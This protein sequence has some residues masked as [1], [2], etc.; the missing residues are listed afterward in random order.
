M[1]VQSFNCVSCLNTILEL[2]NGENVN[3]AIVNECVTKLK[4]A[5]LLAG[6]SHRVKVGQSSH[7]SKKGSWY[8][9][10]CQQ[11]RESFEWAE[12]IYR[13]TG[14][15][16]DR[17]KM[18]EA[19]NV[20]RKCCR[21][22]RTRQHVMDADE[23]VNLGRSN[24]KQ[25]WRKLK[26]R[27]GRVLGDCDFLSYFKKLGDLQS[28]VLEEVEQEIEQWEESNSFHSDETLD[29]EISMDDLELAINKLKSNKS[30]GYDGVLNEF[31]VHGGRLMKVV[32]LKL[33]NTIF[34][35]GCF[36]QVWAVGEIIPVY[37]KGNKNEPENYR[38]I[39]LLSCLGK[40][41]TSILNNRLSIWAENNNVFQENQYGFRKQRSTTDCMFVLHGII[42]LLLN[43]SKPLY[44]AF[45]DLQRAFD[46]ANRRALWFKLSQ[47]S[48]SSKIINL[49]KSMYD[50]IKLC[51][52][53]I[54]GSN[55]LSDSGDDACFFTSK[56]GVFQGEC[57]SGFLFAMFVNDV[58]TFLKHEEDV[59]LRLDQLLLAVLLFADDMVI[60]SESRLGLQKGLNTISRYCDK[61]GLTVNILKTK[62]VAFRKGG[63]VGAL[64]KWTYNN[65]NI[66]T[67]C[68]FKYLGFV[69][70]SSGRFSKG[71]QALADQGQR[72]LFSLKSLFHQHTE[73]SVSTQ[74][75]LFHALIS[76][77]LAYSCEIWGFCEADQLERL[78][79]GFLKSVLGVKKSVPNAFIYSELETF[80]LNIVRK[81]R[82]V[83][84]WLKILKL[85]NSNPVKVV[86][87]MLCQHTD[88]DD[89]IVNWASLLKNMLDKAGFG[90]VWLQQYVENE[91]K[92][93]SEFTK[94]TQDMFLQTCHGNID[95]VSDNRLY[96]CLHS[97]SEGSRYLSEI[98][99]K[100]IRT[101]ISKL[102]LGSH[103]FLIER[104]K[105]Q[106]P[107][108]D[109]SSRKCEICHVIEDE[110]HIMLECKR[111]VDLRNRYL[112]K[113]IIRRPSMY[114]FLNF[115]NTV[116]GKNLQ[117]FGIF[118]YKVL[119]EYN[120][121]VA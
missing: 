22:K 96:K 14:D 112:P 40:L 1:N 41:F 17:V 49:L 16:V 25:F 63:R 23:L 108:L 73:M 39:T 30:A 6:E 82:I 60:F 68:H 99:H 33:F 83:K 75:R 86:Y 27:P 67:V 9:S 26:K 105:W 88:D 56:V 2:L 19:R 81:T 90:Y 13:M 11:K 29:D 48:V 62:C 45:I 118:C 119:T 91:S 64:D 115:L 98:K 50:N 15:D 59:G 87:K 54:T 37:K 47:H 32:M 93:V 97:P 120:N 65:V 24:P 94:R 121:S 100:Y 12:R 53:N 10:E 52:K 92:F 31:I 35:I 69:F 44:C 102:R 78:H 38:G 70:G 104:G 84:F 89:S 55:T 43:K 8:D 42:E 4:D 114:T 21:L 111:F 85:E 113:L 3:E 79:M 61:W 116:E 95:K 34:N 110:Y 66:E 117:S 106:C 28:F 74:L 71:I 36:P 103:N 58:D 7:P 18:C 77:I 72:A 76:P 101:A 109:V 5:L 57:L 20:Y 80:P 107:K 51:L 46:S